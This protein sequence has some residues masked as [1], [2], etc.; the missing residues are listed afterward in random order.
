VLTFA[1]AYLVYSQLP[2]ISGGLSAICNLNMCHAVV[3]KKLSN[4]N[5]INNFRLTIYR[6]VFIISSSGP[7]HCKYVKLAIY[8]E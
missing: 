4:N 3:T 5:R 8:F 7:T 2:F 1:T 6:S